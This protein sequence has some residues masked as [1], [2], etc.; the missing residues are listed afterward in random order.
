MKLFKNFLYKVLELQEKFLRFRLSK[1]IGVKNV[2]KRKRHYSDNCVLDLNTMAD[3]EKQELEDKITAILKDYDYDPLKI[4]EYI[5]SQGTPVVF[6]KDA[7]KLLNPIYE[8]EGFIYPANGT[9]ALYLSLAINHTFALK[10]KEMFVLSEGEINKYYFLYHFYNWFAFKNDIAGMD[11][12]SQELLK[13]YLFSD[14]DTNELQLSEIFKLKD[15][16]KQDKSAIEFVVKLCRNYDGAK[17][18]LDKMK[19]EGSAK[20]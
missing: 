16:I 17:Q 6:L 13:K 2:S 1:T 10:T 15:A 14:S 20:L 9:K 8:N 18:A 11:C 3:A 5:K 7:K 19:N 4:L 12:E